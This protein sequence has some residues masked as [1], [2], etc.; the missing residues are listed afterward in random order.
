MSLSTVNLEILRFST[1]D[2]SALSHYKGDL[3]G[4]IHN[5]FIHLS[6]LPSSGDFRSVW[7]PYKDILCKAYYIKFH[8]LINV[9][10][11]DKKFIFT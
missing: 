4:K 6:K 8:N 9:D 1:R 5:L 11:I 3:M 7:H 2:G 10:M